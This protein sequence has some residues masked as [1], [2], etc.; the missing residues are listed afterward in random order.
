MMDDSLSIRLVMLAAGFQAFLQAPLFGHGWANIMSS[1]L[2]FVHDENQ[3]NIILGLAHL[4]N[5][6]M[7]FAVTGGLVG[8]A[9]YLA[10]IGGPVFAVLKMQ[11]DSSDFARLMAVALLTTSYFFRGLSDL[12]FGFEANSLYYVAFL[13]IFFGLFTKPG[14]KSIPG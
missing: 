11:R 2:E 5:D 10:M 4:H 13:A 7:D 3:R 1:V 6:L 12:M 9:T 8:I 14:P